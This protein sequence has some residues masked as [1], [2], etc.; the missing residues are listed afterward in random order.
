VKQTCT[1][2][3]PPPTFFELIDAAVFLDKEIVYDIC[4]R[5]L[6]IEINSDPTSISTAQ[7]METRAPAALA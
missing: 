5:N 3:T 2:G 7:S 4:S 6:D 1:P